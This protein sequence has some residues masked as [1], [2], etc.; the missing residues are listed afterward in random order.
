MTKKPPK[1]VKGNCT[2]GGNHTPG[3]W[4]A[5]EYSSGPSSGIQWRIKT[6]TKCGKTV[7]SQ[8][9]SV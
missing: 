5:W 9:K 8:A 1:P 4:S 3:S 7:D 6:C 2:G